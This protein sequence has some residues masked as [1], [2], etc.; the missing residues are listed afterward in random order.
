[1]LINMLQCATEMLKTVS[2][3]VLT[4]RL[5][6]LLPPKAPAIIASNNGWFDIHAMLQQQQ[7]KGCAHKR[8]EKLWNFLI[9]DIEIFLFFTEHSR[10]QNFSQ[11]CECIFVKFGNEFAVVKATQF[12]WWL[13]QILGILRFR[14]II[15][16]MRAQS[17]LNLVFR[18]LQ[19]LCCGCLELT[20]E[21]CR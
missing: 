9:N 12:R 7:S 13:Q 3:P 1:M 2:L 5:H 18:A 21:N 6:R 14:I 8:S 17:K 15:L 11:S 19:M 16:L 4:E 10:W 20:T